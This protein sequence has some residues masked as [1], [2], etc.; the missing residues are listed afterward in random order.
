MEDKE[1]LVL[2]GSMHRE[3]IRCCA[4]S[5]VG[6]QT[7]IEMRA[8]RERERESWGRT[9][10]AREKTL[11]RWFCSWCQDAALVLLA[12]NSHLL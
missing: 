10:M 7:E 3:R 12:Y 4:R 9:A 1:V 8:E 11:H 2:V 6:N 5:E